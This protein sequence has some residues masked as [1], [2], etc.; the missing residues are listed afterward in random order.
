MFAS[1][2]F[3]VIQYQEIGMKK[4][5]GLLFAVTLM[6]AGS[7]QALP[8]TIN[9]TADNLVL[10]FGV[11]LNLGC[12][13]LV[14][15]GDWSIL[16]PKGPNAGNWTNADSITFDL[17]PGT[18]D[19]GFVARNSGTPNG[20]NPAGLLAEILWDGNENLSSSNW[21]V[22]TNGVNYVAATEWAQN[23]SGIWG[24]NLLGEISSNAKWLWTA[25][26]FNGLT[27]AVAGF[28]TT[29]TV[30]NVPEPSIIA[31]FGLGLLGLGFARRRKA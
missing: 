20:G 28:R 24:G 4:I 31:L 5:T 27:D 9:Y 19:I 14:D 16:L 30:G 3:I 10:D 25:N 23:G 2:S 8:V 1:Y 6:G 21:D 12:S 22:T 17:G 13:P 15:A 11:C 26:N 7:A 29:I 18:Y